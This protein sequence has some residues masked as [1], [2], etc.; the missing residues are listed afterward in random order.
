MK[1]KNEENN[2]DGSEVEF[3]SA[4]FSVSQQLPLD[5]DLLWT[6]V[7]SSVFHFRAYSPSRKRG[8]NL[9]VHP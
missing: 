1:K 2:G 4:E 9:Q 8:W 7:D 6:V 5:P 3:I